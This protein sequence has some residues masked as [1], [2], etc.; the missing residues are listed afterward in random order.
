MDLIDAYR[1]TD[2]DQKAFAAYERLLDQLKSQK[3][4]N[5]QLY[6]EELNYNMRFNEN[7]AELE[8]LK[9]SNEKA[10]LTRS[11]NNM[12]IAA[13]AVFLALLIVVLCLVVIAKK[14][15]KILA[16]KEYDLLEASLEE[17]KQSRIIYEMKLLKIIEDRERNRIATD[18]HDSLGGLLSSIKIA[19]YDFQESA[20]LSENEMDHLSR[21]LHYVDD[22]K[23]ELNRIVYNLTPLIVEKFGLLEAIKQYCKK[24]QTDKFRIALQ[25]IKVPSQI[26]VEDEITFYRIIQEVLHNIV[27]HANATHVLLQIQTDKSGMLA[28]SIE[29][30]GDGMNLETARLKGGLGLKSIYS[31][32]QNLNGKIS[33]E[34][35]KNEDTSIYITCYPRMIQESDNNIKP[36]LLK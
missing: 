35:N 8:K 11:K 20:P 1:A 30:N 7:L 27:K 3:I 6:I 34:S 17:E 12:L 28:L 15:N 10:Q 4:S 33:V 19:L 14:R 32:V 21:I 31:R 23:Q 16:K 24:I 9:S 18:L 5:Q 2:Q 13:L 22:T 25:L 36:S 26:V 29:D